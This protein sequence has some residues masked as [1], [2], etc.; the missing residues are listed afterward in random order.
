MLITQITQDGGHDVNLLNDARQAARF[1]VARGVEE[2]DRHAETPERRLIF[3]MRGEAGVIGRDDEQGVLV[4]RL[5]ARRR[6]EFA[7]RH[8][9][10]S[11]TFVQGRA[12]F[13]GELLLVAFRHLVGR[14]GRGG[15]N[16]RHERLFHFA[17]LVRIELQE[18]FVPNGPC[19]VELVFAAET[20]VGLKLGAAVVFVE[21]RGAR[22]SLE[23]H[24]SV[25][26]TVEESR[27]VVFLI[28]LA[29][30]S[31][32]VVERSR[33]E[34]KRFD[35]H[36]DRRKHR[37]HAVDAL[38]AV[39]KRVL[40]GGAH[41]DERIEEGRHAFVV[42]AFELRVEGAHKFLAETLENDHDDVLVALSQRLA[43]VV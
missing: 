33:G 10:V 32:Q 1:H 31:T 42:P 26:R 43:R 18:R 21:T 24:R 36:G 8:V 35:K 5:T 20:R 38:A 16:G 7:Q 34:E 30:E 4:P 25:L 29:G 11:H 23:T 3:L 22:K 39:G 6:K 40:V 13:F 41:R 2:D 9:A 28:Q 14:M 37:G 17:H 27:L 19:A 12:A 15:E